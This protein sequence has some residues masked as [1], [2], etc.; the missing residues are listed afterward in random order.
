LKFEKTK[1]KKIDAAIVRS[2]SVDE[3]FTKVEAGKNFL[4]KFGM[5]LEDAHTM[6]TVSL[7]DGD[8]SLYER[9]SQ[10]IDDLLKVSERKDVKSVLDA[11]TKITK[12]DSKVDTYDQTVSALGLE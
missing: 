1:D 10:A 12:V 7:N 9:T 4:V 3:L 11:L 5:A 2:D 8:G 6:L